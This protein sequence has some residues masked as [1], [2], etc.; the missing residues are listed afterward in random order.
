[1]I[2]VAE[3]EDNSIGAPR[4]IANSKRTGGTLLSVLKEQLATCDT[5]D[6]CVAFVANGGL[7]MLVETLSE[8]KRKGVK[9]RFLTS[10]YLNFNSPDV[11]RKLLEYDN[12]EVRVYQ[13]DMHAKGYVF[14]RNGSS[15]IIVGSSNFTQKA[16]TCNK[17]WNVL[18]Q[19]YG[20]D[21][22]LADLRGEFSSLWSSED[23]APLS[24]EWIAGY[25]A[26]R[27][28]AATTTERRPAFE[29]REKSVSDSRAS[30][31]IEPNKM[32]KL[33]LE[34]LSV[35]HGKGERRALLISATGT[36]KTYLSAFDVV[37]SKPKRVLFLAHRKR[38]LDASLKS[39][40]KLL[41]ASYQFAMYETGV[42][43]SNDTCVFAMCSTMALHLSEFKPDEFDYIIVDEAHRT[44]SKSYQK[45]MG[46][47]TPKFYLGMTATPN[48]SDGYDV[49]A[50]F[51]HVIAFQITLQDALE[52]EMLAPFHYFGIADLEIDDESV[53]NPALFA[54]LASSERVKHITSKIEEYVVDKSNRKGLIFCNRNEEAQLL[55]KQFNELGYRT[56]AI[57]GADSDA[58]RDDAIAK[59][60]SGE[61]E[62]LFSVDILNEG[63]DIPTVN[64]VIMLRRTDSSIVFVQQL[65]R[66]LR[67]AD[68]KEYTLV[69]DFIGNYQ[70]NFFVPVALSG[71]K[72]FNKDKLR[73]IVH[74]GDTVVPG[75]S[76]VSFD[77]V[78]KARI[79]RAIDG[80]NFTAV[81]FLKSA[82]SDLKQ[83]LGHIPALS[84]FDA[85]GSIDPL[86]IFR[87]FGSYHAF[88]TNADRD[89]ECK[90]NKTQT[91]A[92]K[93][94][95][96]KL[97]NGKR[98]EELFLL[99]ELVER[100]DATADE[101]ERDARDRYAACLRK[102]TVNS[103]V[104]TLYGAFN[105][106][107]DFVALAVKDDHG[108]H[109]TKELKTALEDDEFKRQLMELIDFGMERNRRDYGETYGDTNFVLNA[110]Y[111]YEEV[112]RL[113]NWGKNV[114]G[115]NIGGY[116]Y[117]ETTNT[118]PVFINY[119]KDPNVSDSIKY[120]D[121]FVSD[122]TL[123]GITKQPRY[124]NSPEVMR[125]QA[126]P[127]NGMKTYLF[128]RKSKKDGTSKEFYFLGEMYPTGKYIPVKVG[129]TERP[130][131]EIEY[132]LV[133][134]VRRDIYEFMLSDLG[135][136]DDDADE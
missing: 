35:I 89:Y 42:D 86:L 26:Y 107:A 118:F 55:S 127:E 136:D 65:G 102:D 95:S 4:L 64:Q 130:A 135:G 16:L 48:R 83:Q 8:L 81:R 59:L 28:K 71:D 24:E 96:Q 79:Y 116:K 117:D 49:F 6:F 120:E 124:M 90:F 122:D 103:A 111:T 82:Y 32:Q 61:L 2:D 76:T 52:N 17:E 67:K 45:I 58:V 97:A 31:K 104:A 84:E 105:K 15:T 112:C 80:G 113:L 93:F 87:K 1:M 44:G 72:T 23:T 70:K 13:G 134:P 94:I 37:E 68:D 21:G 121:R 123:L 66:G 99:R 9:G 115:Q 106:P 131:V 12:I 43:V 57:S 98:F 5:F 108:F 62:Y 85:N 77:E 110:K 53:D 33:A 109:L 10:T 30:K 50:L 34:A 11:L 100:R 60:E 132:R 14:D 19:T 22:F 133:N 41:G 88:L 78:S 126:W 40:K 101:L 91:N 3:H 36:G 92:L 20:E 27:P 128:M 125:L 73:R 54:R 129:E 114:N 74:E 119:D 75:C 46:Y 7:Q 38:I 18:Y 63:V 56:L 51:N 29:Y 47:F 39:Y 69:L 25:E